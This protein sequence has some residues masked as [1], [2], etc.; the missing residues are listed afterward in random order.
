MGRNTSVRTEF[1]W[2]K[3]QHH[4]AYAIASSE[5]SRLA[6]HECME[7]L[8]MILAHAEEELLH[9]ALLDIVSAALPDEMGF[10]GPFNVTKVRMPTADEFD[11][12]ALLVLIGYA[13][14]TP[15]TGELSIFI[16][17]HTVIRFQH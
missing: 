4:L 5:R 8:D 17:E 10:T 3:P 16:T 7:M 11:G 6:F 9:Y 13:Q 1:N 14:D 12:G 15:L 2:H